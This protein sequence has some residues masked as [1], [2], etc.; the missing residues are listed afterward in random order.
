M[1]HQQRIIDIMLTPLK[2]FFDEPNYGQGSKSEV[3]NTWTEEFRWYSNASLQEAVKFVKTQKVYSRTKWHNELFP[4]LADRLKT[5]GH[6]YVNNNNDKKGLFVDAKKEFAN[7]YWSYIQT[8]NHPE[9]GYREYKFKE[10][11][12]QTML[13]EAQVEFKADIERLYIKTVHELGALCW[14]KGLFP[15]KF[16][17]RYGAEVK[18]LPELAPNKARLLNKKQ[19]ET[20][21]G[22][23]S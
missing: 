16:N 1:N 4:I 10:Q 11:L 2:G 15:N 17:K 18:K 19:A 3:I 12:M 7:W 6:S 9:E 22:V 23:A 14:H 8:W 20:L 13:A 5:K 21:S